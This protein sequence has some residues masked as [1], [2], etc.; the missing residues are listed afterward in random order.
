MMDP[1]DY[2][3]LA[4]AAQDAGELQAG[5]AGVFDP[6][7]E[8]LGDGVIVGPYGV[9][10]LQL[11]YGLAVRV[12]GALAGLRDGI[13]EE[14]A[15][16]PV[17]SGCQPFSPVAGPVRGPLGVSDAGW[18]AGTI[19][20]Y[21]D[22]AEEMITRI[23]QV[24]QTLQTEVAERAFQVCYA[25][26]ISG[27]QAFTVGEAGAEL[28]DVA[29]L[30]RARLDVVEHASGGHLTDAETVTPISTGSPN[31]WDRTEPVRK[32]LEGLLA[33]FDFAMGDAVIDFV[34][35]AAK[36][37]TERVSE[38]DDALEEAKGVSDLAAR[39][40]LLIDLGEEFESAGNSIQTWTDL[41]PGWMRAAAESMAEIRGFGN[42]MSVLGII[43]DTGTVVSPQNSG[44]FGDVDRGVAAVNG[45][46]LLVGMLPMV[47]LG[48]IGGAVIAATGL[49]LA[50]DWAYHH[51]T[52]FRDV[53]NDIGHAVVHVTADA[54]HV[55]ED[56]GHDAR[57][58]WHSVTST[59]GSWF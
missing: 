47:E 33:P 12:S 52:P 20:I 6:V 17:P 7:L 4:D 43:A 55:A 30:V 29:P 26:D 14:L 1:A 3:R 24:S 23:G 16:A 15:R 25:A 49:Y 37:P 5:Y 42:T 34:K 40:R 54:V 51:W 46:L 8:L 39:S 59:I 45:G 18:P 2:E 35:N 22:R 36:F 53:A 31:A 27:S 28:A 9:E 38:L 11:V 32:I 19:A 21:P 57:S 56:A 58:A 41:A 13:E 44:K 50:G 48:P 10:L